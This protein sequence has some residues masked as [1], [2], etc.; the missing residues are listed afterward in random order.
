MTPKEWLQVLAWAPLWLYVVVYVA[1]KLA[2][3]VF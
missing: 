3:L 1:A 2:H